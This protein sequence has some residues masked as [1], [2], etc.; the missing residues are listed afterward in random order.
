[1]AQHSSGRAQRVLLVDSRPERRRLLRQILIGAGLTEASIDEADDKDTALS[2]IEPADEGLVVLELLP[3]DD[4]L[5]AI[6]E[7]RRSAPRLRIVV[8]SFRLDPESRRQATD[9]GADACLDK[10]VRTADV[11][12]LMSGLYPDGL[13]WADIESDDGLPGADEPTQLTSWVP[14]APEELPSPAGIAG[15]GPAGPAGP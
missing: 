6:A 1:M 15:G 3:L 13:P 4:A 9:A 10:P 8:C 11:R 7:L 5:V 2:R 12:A 14:A